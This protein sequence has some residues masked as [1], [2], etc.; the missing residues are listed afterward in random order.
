MIASKL[1][2]CRT[3]FAQILEPMLG[4]KFGCC[5][6]KTVSSLECGI[7]MISQRVAPAIQQP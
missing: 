1:T 6:L 7:L 2:K 4:S 5:C 3:F